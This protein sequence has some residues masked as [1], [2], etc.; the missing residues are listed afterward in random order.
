MKNLL[1]LSMAVLCMT[2]C[3]S[4]GE[5]TKTREEADSLQAALMVA[6]GSVDLYTQ[7]I[8]IMD[9]IEGS[10]MALRIDLESGSTYDDYVAKMKAIKNQLSDASAKIA[11]LESD[12]GKNL[13]YIRSLKKQLAD[14][15]A[16][17]AQL[18]AAIEGYQESLKMANEENTALISMVDVQGAELDMK[19]LEI[20]QKR[21]ELAYLE[22]KIAQM[23]QQ[24]LISEA[25]AYYARA[26]AT[27][28]AAKRTQ[29]APKKKRETL[30]EA[31][32][33]YEKSLSLG[34]AEAQAKIDALKEKLK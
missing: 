18:T 26:E 34:K 29:L 24:S 27:E 11:K 16:E 19:A 3:V 28:I 5:Y 15:N 12:A 30:E 7:I 23:T 10:Q 20:E 8:T 25:D 4:K 1:I 21:Q 33:L 32:K 14:K 2:G 31:L 17:I 13:K 6:Q 22:E 9:S